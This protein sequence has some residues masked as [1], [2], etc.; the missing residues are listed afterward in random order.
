MSSAVWVMATNSPLCCGLE[1]LGVDQRRR[2]DAAGGERRRQRRR[3]H[4]D[5]LDVAALQRDVEAVTS[6]SAMRISV[7]PAEPMR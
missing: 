5:E 2:I 1:G 3:R 7:M 4:L 6:A